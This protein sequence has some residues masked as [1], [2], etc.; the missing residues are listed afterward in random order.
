[1]KIVQAEYSS[2]LSQA[3]DMTSNYHMGLLEEKRDEIQ[4]II[5]KR[6]RKAA[7]VSIVRT[8]ESQGKPTMASFVGR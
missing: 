7:L 2:R 6:Q 8:G 1:M 4:K 5:W 3:Q